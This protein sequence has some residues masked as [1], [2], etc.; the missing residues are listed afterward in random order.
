MDLTYLLK[1][2]LRNKWIIL[3]SAVMGAAA[4]VAFTF[5]QK[6]AYVS[7]AQYST[8]LTQTQKVS[9]SL[10]EILDVN[11]IDSRFSNII[12]TFK[13]QNVLGMLAG[14]ELLLHDLESLGPSGTD[15]QTKE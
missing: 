2:L 1:A 14:Y 5:V 3:L 13:S 4:G 9:L 7:N 15:Q 8:G 10:T 12:E 11:Q 6:K